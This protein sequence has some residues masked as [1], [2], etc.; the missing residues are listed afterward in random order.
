MKPLTTLLGLPIAA[1]LFGLGWLARRIAEAA[2][3]EMYSAESIQ[4]E[5][6]ALERRLDDGEIDLADFE[7]EEARLLEVLAEIEAPEQPA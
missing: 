1:P 3:H 7:T 2:D 4:A 6:L 5:L